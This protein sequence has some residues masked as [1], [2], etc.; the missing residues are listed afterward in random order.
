MAKLTKMQD[1]S[2]KHVDQQDALY[3]V[4]DANQIKSA[5]DSRAKELR[6]YLNNLIELLNSDGASHITTLPINDLEV[7]EQTIQKVLEALMET[8]AN[9]DNVF[10]KE[11]LIPFLQGG[12]TEIMVEIF[13]IVAGNN[14]DGTF[15]YETDGQQI[16]GELTPE[17]WQ[18]FKLKKG[19]FIP[20]KNRLEVTIDDHSHRSEASGGVIEIDETTFV[21]T[22]PESAGVE[23]T[24]KYYERIGAAAEYNIRVSPTSQKPPNVDKTIMWFELIED[25][26]V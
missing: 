15:T 25:G 16:T 7:P 18:I 13:N 19:H 24:V 20:H 14:G 10:T 1:F 9:K 26:E 17:G 6:I 5:F 12:D 4:L 2:F 21:L 22:M 8:K 23:V 11:E 3:R